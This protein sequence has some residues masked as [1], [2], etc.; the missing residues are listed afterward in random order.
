MYTCKQCIWCLGGLLFCSWHYFSSERYQNVTT[1]H[2]ALKSSCF[3]KLRISSYP[4]QSPTI[5]HF[6]GTLPN[7]T[8]STSAPAR[9]LATYQELYALPMGPPPPE[10]KAPPIETILLTNDSEIHLL[11]MKTT[12]AHYRIPCTHSRKLP[13]RRVVDT[14]HQMFHPETRAV[15]I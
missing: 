14:K 15:C 8:L 9:S 3:L 5:R 11:Q 12:S 4:P 1:N 13:W 2:A 6:L 10:S 7:I